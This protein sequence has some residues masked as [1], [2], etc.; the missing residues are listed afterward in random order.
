MITFSLFLRGLKFPLMQHEVASLIKIIRNISDL[1]FCG[2]QFWLCT[3]KQL[4]D[5]DLWL[6]GLS[7]LGYPLLVVAAFCVVLLVDYSG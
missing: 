2:M 3:G 6:L 1:V 7:L 5:W 4:F